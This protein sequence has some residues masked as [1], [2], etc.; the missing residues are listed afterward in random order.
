M[1]KS[2]IMSHLCCSRVIFFSKKQDTHT[3]LCSESK[4][5]VFSRPPQHTI[6]FYAH[7][8]DVYLDLEKKK[9]VDELIQGF[10]GIETITQKI[11][12]FKSS[13][14]SCLIFD[15]SLSMIENEISTL[16]SA[17]SH[18]QNCDIFFISQ[19]LFYDHKEYRTMGLN[20]HYLFL[21]KNPSNIRQ[22]NFSFY[23][24]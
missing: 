21:M 17:V 22:V 8:Q 24:K 3:I 10:P 19:N 16:F 5:I 11:N 23:K 18:H 1:R 13:G 9:L 20:C 14:G 12:Q 15:D 7:P 2:F 4:K 6:L